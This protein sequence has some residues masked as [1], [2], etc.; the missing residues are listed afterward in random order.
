M[1]AESRPVDPLRR[2]LAWL[3][4]HELGLLLAIAGIALGVW[5]FV[6]L[7]DEVSEGG[8]ANVDLH[9]LLVM[10]EPGNPADPLGPPVVEEAARDITAL[11]GVIVLGL[12]TTIV[13]GYLILDGKA[14]MALFV[15]ASI[16]TGMLTSSGMKHLFNRPRPDIALHASYTAGT[17]FPSGHS[18]MSAATYLTLGALLARSE[19]RKRLKAYFL[20]VAVF[21]MVAVGVTRVYLGVHW[22]TDVLGGWTAGAVWA[23]LCWTLAR[24]LQSERSI[25]QESEHTPAPSISQR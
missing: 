25:E 18:M 10:R 22:P 7:A 8:T 13:G 2:L 9:I 1:T 6:L 5:M 4:S 21:L 3:G 24:W 12:L 20:I 11:G 17:S 14:R 23:L 16:A 19:T 15:W